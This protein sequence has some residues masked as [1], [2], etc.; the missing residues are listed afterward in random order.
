MTTFMFQILRALGNV[1]FDSALIDLQALFP[2]IDIR[3]PSIH[4][5]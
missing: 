2:E 5:F 1:E 4:I 3:G